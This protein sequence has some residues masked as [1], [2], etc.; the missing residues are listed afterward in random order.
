MKFKLPNKKRHPH[1]D[2]YW[3]VLFLLLS[4]TLFNFSLYF[5]TNSLPKK[6]L[7]VETSNEREVQD[8][9]FWQS[10][11]AKNPEYFPGLI[12]LA[13]IQIKLGDKEAYDQ[14]ISKIRALG[15]NSPILKYLDL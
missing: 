8:L 2:V 3:L 12:E 7:G 13:K 14:T 4:L 9:V 6:V 1:L 5:Y 15:P 10:F 11:L